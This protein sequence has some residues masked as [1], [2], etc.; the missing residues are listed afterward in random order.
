[1]I[2]PGA[3]TLGAGTTRQKRAPQAA[4]GGG[5]SE[6]FDST[7]FPAQPSRRTKCD[8]DV[9][10]KAKK[11]LFLARM[12][13]VNGTSPV[14]RP[15]EPGRVQDIVA[16]PP[17]SLTPRSYDPSRIAPRLLKR[18]ISRSA[19]LRWVDRSAATVSVASF[20]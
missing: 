4:Q 14:S 15:D 3:S 12:G 18:R 17:R 1:M 16:P 19:V 10:K 13:E 8:R 7:P 6:A 11:T 20:R 5:N 9:S 2:A